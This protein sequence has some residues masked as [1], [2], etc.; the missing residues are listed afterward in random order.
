[1]CFGQ[2]HKD[3]SRPGLIALFFVE[4]AL[5]GVVSSL[6]Y[7]YNQAV[8]KLGIILN[9]YQPVVQEEKK[10]RE[11]AEKSYLPLIKIIKNRKEFRP[12][13]NI[14]LGLLQQM[15]AYGYSSWIKDIKDLL[16]EDRVE[17]V[18]S[19]AYNGV[20]SEIPEP[21]LT[22]QIVLN[23]YGAGYFLGRRSGFE[24]E[25]A[26]LVKGLEGFVAP[27]GFANQEVLDLVGSLGY[28]WLL[29]DPEV[30]GGSYGIFDLGAEKECRLLTYNKQLSNAIAEKSDLEINDITPLVRES[31]DCVIL[32][33][34]EIFGY[35]NKD[36]VY[37]L[38]QILDSL[39]DSGVQVLPA[40][41][42][43]EIEVGESR[44]SQIDKVGWLPYVPNNKELWGLNQEILSILAE[45]LAKY[46]KLE[47][48][49]MENIPVWANELPEEVRIPV[50]AAQLCDRSQFENE[51][52]RHNFAALYSDLG[53]LHKE[54]KLA[55]LIKDI[56]AIL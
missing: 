51:D 9:L 50:I 26:V 6:P 42:F 8:K 2:E 28:S 24:G 5:L 3:L 23:E 11:I 13:L 38:N 53:K 31:K 22:N 48:E 36:G 17:L 1:M 49:G 44:M 54:E 27:G 46:P 41:E 32:L 47:V 12:T 56:E 45:F 19:A 4:L 10:L 43:L 30:V 15:D 25:S 39:R 55:T 7:V 52:L 20:L 34:A 14:P 21:L 16:E 33:D 29:A 18:G 35:K 37:L 40:G